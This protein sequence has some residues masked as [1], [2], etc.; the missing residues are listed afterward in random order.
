MGIYPKAK[1]AMWPAIV[2]NE[3]NPPPPLGWM[4]YKKV[5]LD[6][7]IRFNFRSIK[8]VEL[9]PCDP[10]RQRKQR[11][12]GDLWANV[13]HNMNFTKLF[14]RKMQAEPI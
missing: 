14:C 5:G 3:A 2:E 1:N 10:D 9:A 6:Q 11:Q 7:S 12:V 8:D 4:H 13:M